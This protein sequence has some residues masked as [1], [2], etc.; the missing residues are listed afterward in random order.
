MSDP[1]EN[2]P[3]TEAVEDLPYSSELEKEWAVKALALMPL[4]SAVDGFL[5][6]FPHYEDKKY[7]SRETIHR[8]LTTRL[9]AYLYDDRGL[10][11]EKIQD[12]KEKLKL[13]SELTGY[14]IDPIEV[15][16][17]MCKIYRH[18]DLKPIEKTRLGAQILKI[19]Q[20]LEGNPDTT[21]VS[22]EVTW[23]G[24]GAQF[25]AKEG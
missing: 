1:I 21:K 19:R 16:I 15:Y 11:R 6:A 20:Q 5:M 2:A 3:E 10:Q 25:E 7:G 17:D 4:K 23:A 18:A 12:A 9:K 24:T 14:L 8:K 13:Q 22:E